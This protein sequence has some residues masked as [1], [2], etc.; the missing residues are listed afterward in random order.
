MRRP[1]PVRARTRG[2]AWSVHERNFVP[3]GPI[4]TAW[5][6]RRSGERDVLGPRQRARRA[7]ACRHP[8]PSSHRPDA[9]S[10]ADP[11]PQALQEG[12]AATRSMRAPRQDTSRGQSEPPQNRR[13]TCSPS[14]TFQRFGCFDSQPVR[15]YTRIDIL[16]FARSL[17][18]VDRAIRGS[19]LCGAPTLTGNNNTKE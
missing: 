19:P 4:T 7:A 3:A 18:A 15:H 13:P 8:E 14:E 1:S 12:N 17:G 16:D 2:T 10:S 5:G 11:L 9:E 6:L